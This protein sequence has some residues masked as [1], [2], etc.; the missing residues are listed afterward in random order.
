LSLA[1]EKGW[2]SNRAEALKILGDG[3]LKQALTIKAD[4]ISKSAKTKLEAA[5][6]T[7][8]LSTIAPSH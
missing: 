4:K 8:A 5:G 2:V 6:C 1:K 7:I 3:E